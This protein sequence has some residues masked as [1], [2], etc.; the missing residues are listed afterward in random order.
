MSRSVTRVVPLDG[1]RIRLQFDDGVEGDV[2]LSDLAGRGVFA[3]WMDRARFERVG[4]GEGG[5]VRWEGD[6]EL[7][8]DALYLRLTGKP[9]EDVF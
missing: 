9:V 3:I 6:A 4:I 5:S 8:P 7:C 2:D 1:F